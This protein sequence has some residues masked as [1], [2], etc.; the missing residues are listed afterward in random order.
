MMNEPRKHQRQFK[1]AAYRDHAID[2]ARQRL[3]VHL[4][5]RGLER[6]IEQIQAK[7]A[8]FLVKQGKEHACGRWREIWLVDHEG[9]QLAAVW[10]RDSRQ[11]VSFLTPEMINAVYGKRFNNETA[12]TMNGTAAL[13]ESAW[14]GGVKK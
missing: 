6:L 8:R 9:Q 7:R 1:R 4:T 11:I 3:G 12:V 5:R 10:D 2:R 14:T 13:T